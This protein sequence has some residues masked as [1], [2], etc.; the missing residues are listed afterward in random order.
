MEIVRMDRELQTKRMV[1]IWMTG[2]GKY[3]KQLETEKERTKTNWW[4]ST[5]GELEMER[6]GTV[7]QL[8]AKKML[9]SW[10]TGEG[11]DEIHLEAWDRREWR[12]TA[13]LEKERKVSEETKRRR[14]CTYIGE[15]E[16]EKVRMNGELQTKRMENS[17]RTGEE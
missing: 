11:D 5:W 16:M 6:L 10:R 2:E 4:Q 8:Q 17:W 1:N 12:K 14:Q 13:E 15:L 3:E 9:S 7:G